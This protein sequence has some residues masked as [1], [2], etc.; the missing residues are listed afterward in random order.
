MN[1]TIRNLS[2]HELRAVGAFKLAMRQL[3]VPGHPDGKCP[4][5]EHA[6]TDVGS[7]AIAQRAY[8]LLAD[9]DIA[10]ADVCIDCMVLIPFIAECYAVDGATVCRPCGAARYGDALSKYTIV[11][12]E[13]S[14]RPAAG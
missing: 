14:Q 7:D 8:E 3:G 6:C 10:D 12:P 13:A 4:P 5:G 11:G 9:P 1:D 2:P